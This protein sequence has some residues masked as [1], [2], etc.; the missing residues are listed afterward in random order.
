MI[1]EL[2]TQ[3][4]GL[5]ER[6]EVVVTADGFAGDENLRHGA[7]ASDFDEPGTFRVIAADVDLCIAG[8]PFG[9][10]A[11]GGGAVSAYARRIDCD[12]DGH[13]LLAC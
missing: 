12:V 5:I 6:G 9:K 8:A 7:A 1:G 3:L 13:R 4:A 2:V 11:L 10:K